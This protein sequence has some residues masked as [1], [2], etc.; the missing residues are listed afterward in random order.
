MSANC[1]L[2]ELIVLY[3]REEREGSVWRNILCP[4]ASDARICRPQ[5]PIYEDIDGKA[6]LASLEVPSVG[7]ALRIASFKWIIVID[8][9]GKSLRSNFY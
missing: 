8:K 6:I 5:L 3:M 7:H 9:T 4:V 2:I 1:A